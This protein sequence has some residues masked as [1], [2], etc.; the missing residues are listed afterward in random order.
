MSDEEAR[1][2]LVRDPIPNRHAALH[3]LV[4][5]STRQNSLN[6][7]FIGDYVFELISVLKELQQSARTKGRENGRDAG[8]TGD[9]E[10]CGGSAVSITGSPY[11]VNIES[12]TT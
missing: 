4:V 7:I 3:G 1:Q 9:Q 8:V 6:V 2:R 5:Y 10:E 11:R 12:R